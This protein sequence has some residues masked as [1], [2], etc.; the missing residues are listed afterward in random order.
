MKETHIISLLESVSFASL[1]EA[2]HVEIRTHIASCSDCERAYKVA[3]V[4]SSLLKEGEGEV[5]EPSPFF[6]TRVLAAVR[7]QQ[8]EPRGWQRMWRAA[9]ALVSSMTATVA[10]L[11]VISFMVPG[12]PSTVEATAVNRYFAED[13]ILDQQEIAQEQPSDAEVLSTLYQAEEDER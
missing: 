8:A 10:L 1:S 5:F 7:E 4:S 12:T 9:G 2:E 6:Q 11:A 13:V 3:M